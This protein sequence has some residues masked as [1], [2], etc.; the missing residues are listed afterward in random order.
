MKAINTV[1][2]ILGMTTVAAAQ[3][4]VKATTEEGRKVLLNADGTWKYAEPL[5]VAPGAV[6]AAA[7]YTRSKT[8]TERVKTVVD[9][10]SLWMDPDVW[11]QDK[12]DDPNRLEFSHKKGDAYALVI[13]ERIGMPLESLMDVAI[14]NAKEAAPDLKVTFKETRVVNGANVLCMK[15]VG[16][17]QKIPF[18][19]FGY[20]YAGKAG[21][22]QVLTYT[23]ENLFD[24]YKAD[25]QDFLN[26]TV[27]SE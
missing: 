11:T 8:A 1:I 5:K 9:K 2:L 7:G 13:A 10:F 3:T 20:Y 14:A 23:G 16:T 17:I 26:G 25:F 15:M 21:S 12:S 4:P 18:I 24:E 6:V 27:I 22:L 19:Y